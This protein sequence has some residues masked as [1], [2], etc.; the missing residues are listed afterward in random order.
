VIYQI[1]SM[2]GGF[3]HVWGDCGVLQKEKNKIFGVEEGEKG[4]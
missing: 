4:E 2:D 3:S 1:G